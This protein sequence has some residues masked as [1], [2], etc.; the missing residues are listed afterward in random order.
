MNETIAKIQVPAE[1]ETSHSLY[2][3]MT[4]KKV[5]MELSEKK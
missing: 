2:Q 4:I 3:Q 1:Q 5:L